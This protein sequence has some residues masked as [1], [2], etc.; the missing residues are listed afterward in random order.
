MKKLIEKLKNYNY[1]DFYFQENC[2]KNIVKHVPNKEYYDWECNIYTYLLKNQKFPIAVPIT[3]SKNCFIYQTNKLKPLIEVLSTIKKRNLII[4]ELF[5]FVINLRSINFVH[6]NLHIYN[7]FY[8]REYS[9]FYL[10]N[11]TDST[12]LGYKEKPKFNQQN[13]SRLVQKNDVLFHDLLTIYSSLKNFFKNDA[14]M[15]KY[16]TEII[17][18]F[19]PKTVIY[20]FNK[21]EDF[22]K[23]A[24]KHLNIFFN[25]KKKM[26]F[27][28]KLQEICYT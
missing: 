11:L 1:H 20:E 13:Y 2:D 23:N 27:I 19:I 17:C 5:S 10:L 12:I 6:G 14:K 8:D 16:L 22:M 4:N 9:Q 26:N 21:E 3:P 7:V 15:I 18:V 25:E 28:N 24:H